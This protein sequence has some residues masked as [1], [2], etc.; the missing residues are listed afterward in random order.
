MLCGDLFF[1]PILSWIYPNQASPPTYID[2]QNCESHKSMILTLQKSSHQFPALSYLEYLELCPPWKAFF[3]GLQ[4][5]VLSRDCFF[6]SG[7]SFQV[8]FASSPSLSLSLTVNLLCLARW[9]LQ[10]S[11]FLYILSR[12]E[13]LIIMIFL[14]P[15]WWLDLDLNLQACISKVPAQYPCLG[16][17]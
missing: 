11:A 5:P 13:N 4:D 1:L 17:L 8:F 16:V 7:S 14:P 3:S 9:H 10:S 15:T 2:T 12:H 6:V